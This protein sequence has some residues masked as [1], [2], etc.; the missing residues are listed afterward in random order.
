MN[1]MTQVPVVRPVDPADAAKVRALRL[2]MLADAPL[3]FIERI[4]E[5]AAR[6]HAEFRSRLAARISGGDSAQY[7]AEVGSRLVGQAG[8]LANSRPSGTALLYAVYVSPPWRRTDLLPR[9]VEATACWARQAGLSTLVLEVVTSNHRAIR[10]YT[11]L[12]FVD[13]GRRTTHPTIPVLTQ[14]MMSR[15]A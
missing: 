15:P 6:P 10:A 1:R 14:L 3:A 12:G 5:A 8:V 2:E 13:T 4:D 11:R 7:V 9:L